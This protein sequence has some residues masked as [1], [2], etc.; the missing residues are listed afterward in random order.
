M[1][2][3]DQAMGIGPGDNGEGRAL[4][5]DREAKIN[6]SGEEQERSSSIGRAI[7]FDNDGREKETR[8]EEGMLASVEGLYREMKPLIVLLLKGVC[9]ECDLAIVAVIK[10]LAWCLLQANAIAPQH[11]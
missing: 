2:S 1:A 4:N 6:R 3:Q 11:G 9:D 10:L 7:C 5:K 8:V